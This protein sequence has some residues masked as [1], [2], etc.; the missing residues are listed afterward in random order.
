MAGVAAALHACLDEL[1]PKTNGALR[2][3]G[4]GRLFA[5]VTQLTRTK[6]PG[7]P[8][9]I[10]GVARCFQLRITVAFD[11]YS[12]A[13]AP[14]SFGPVVLPP[15]SATDLVKRKSVLY[16]MVVKTARGFRFSRCIQA[17]ELYFFFTSAFRPTQ[18][19]V[20]NAD[21]LHIDGK[22]DLFALA[23]ILQ[24]SF[25]A[26]LD[27]LERKKH[28]H[29]DVH[30][31]WE[32]LDFMLLASMLVRDAGLYGNFVTLVRKRKGRLH[33]DP[34]DRLLAAAVPSDCLQEF[35]DRGTNEML[36]TALHGTAHRRQPQPRAPARH[37]DKVAAAA[38]DSELSC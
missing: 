35:I 36:A 17:R 29:F 5:T 7:K 12:V 23:T 6:R 19:L 31:S 28:L 21:A 16:G 4:A 13:T 18:F 20:D 34:V 15:C 3:T 33:R 24:G 8:D 27:P 37:G 2:R 32:P 38:S 11:T 25:D 9:F 10:R 1:Q 14:M 30:L 22:S 26:V